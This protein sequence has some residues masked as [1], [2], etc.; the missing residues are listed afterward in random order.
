MPEPYFAE[1]FSGEGKAVPVY[2]LTPLEGTED[3]HHWQASTIR[4]TCLWVQ[5][6][7]EVDAR[8]QISRATF[9]VSRRKLSEKKASTPWKDTTLVSCETDNSQSVPINIIR[10]RYRTTKLIDGR[11]QDTDTDLRSKMAR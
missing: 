1:H 4:P 8:Q 6:Y 5:A 7:D 2:R 9:V 11:V 10:V 3:S